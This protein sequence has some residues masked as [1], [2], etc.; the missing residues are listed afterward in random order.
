MEPSAPDRILQPSAERW[1]L[2]ANGSTGLACV[3]PT[4]AHNRGPEPIANGRTDRPVGANREMHRAERPHLLLQ[5]LP[6]TNSDTISWLRS[7]PSP[8]PP[9]E[10]P[11]ASNIFTEGKPDLKE[12]S[13]QSFFCLEV[14]SAIGQRGL[15]EQGPRWSN[16]CT[17]SSALTCR[18][19]CCISSRSE[20]QTCHRRLGNSSWSSACRRSASRSLHLSPPR[21]P[22]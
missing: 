14:S 5:E 17:Q 8:C 1:E 10:M 16:K 19:W 18:P 3:R 21:N 7:R 22:P 9:K 20:T 2:T 6:A 13:S 12:R 11:D 15:S 4:P